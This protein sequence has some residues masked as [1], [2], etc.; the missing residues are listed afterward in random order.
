MTDLLKKEIKLSASP[1]S[2]YFILS[3]L[4]TFV[5]GYPILVGVFFATLGIFYSFQSMRENNDI[6]YSM[7]LPISKSDIVKSKFYF[8][9]FVEA[10]NFILMTA[11]TLVRMIFLSKTHVY[12][13]NVLMPANLVFLG[14]SLIVFGL[15]NYVFV[16]GFFKTAYY[17][18]K[19]FVIYCITAFLAVFI[20]ESLRYIPKIKILSSLGFEQ[21]LPQISVLIIGIILFLLLTV[22][23]IKRSE[24]S[25]EKTDL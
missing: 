11:F 21:I 1:L 5:P 6:K 9:V 23:A 18:G 12:V 7:L 3:S 16:S 17:F 14:F 8:V 10:L 20:F 15:Y 22:L 24:K 13:T 4:L 2:F 19:P 25:F